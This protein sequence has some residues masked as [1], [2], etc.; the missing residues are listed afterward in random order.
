MSKIN[1]SS[2]MYTYQSLPSA[3]LDFGGHFDSFRDK[4]QFGTIHEW[5]QHTLNHK[6]T[7]WDVFR[8][9]TTCASRFFKLLSC[10]IVLVLG[11]V[12]I[13]YR[14]CIKLY[15]LLTL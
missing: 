11:Y 15:T 8:S 4:I 14:A 3:I 10:L 13:L 5:I 2:V 6:T 12:S 9:K 7:K 1:Q